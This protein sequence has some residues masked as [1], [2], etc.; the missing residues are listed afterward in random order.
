M[1]EV[2]KCIKDRYSCRDFSP[3]PLTDEQVQTLVEAALAA[4]SALNRMPWHI[5]AVTDKALIEEMDA[6]AM[7]IAAGW[8]DKSTYERMISRGGKMFYD[9]PCLIFV[10]SD[11]SEWST[12]DCGIV[13][14][15]IA[16]AAHSLGLGSVICGMA[17]IPLGG[18]R[19]EEFKKRL[20]FPEG[21]TFGMSVCVGKAKSGKAPHE[22][23]M[24]KVT[25]VK[26]KRSF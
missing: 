18:S 13:S 15:N 11:G 19:G 3:E 1:N 17:R 21:Y 4:P 12:L 22:L 25:Y 16:L 2:I 20:K 9:A 6:E 7:N 10:A 5:I 26:N 14:Q 24:N 23:D 8:D